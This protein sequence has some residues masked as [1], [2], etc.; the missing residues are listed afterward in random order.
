VLKY[1]FSLPSDKWNCKTL[2]FAGTIQKRK[3]AEREENRN[4][5]IDSDIHFKE[6]M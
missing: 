4:G 3:L 2:G 1:T 5:K 6:S